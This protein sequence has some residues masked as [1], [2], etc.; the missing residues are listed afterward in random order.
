RHTIRCFDDKEVGIVQTPQFFRVSSDNWVERGAAAQQEMFYRIGMR[1]RDRRQA[2]ICVGTNAVYRREAL[3]SR[4]GMALLEHSEDIFTGMKVMDAGYRVEYLPLVLAA[5]S[6]PSTTASLASQQYRWARGNFALTT[7]PLFKRMRMTPMQR[8]SIWEGWIFYVTSALSPVVAI[9]VPVLT[10]AEAP[11]AISLAPTAMLLPALFTEFVVQPRWLHLPDGRASRRVGVISQVAHLHALRDHLTDRDQEWIPTGGVR[12]GTRRQP[13]DRIPDIVAGSAV[14]GFVTILVMVGVR[15]AQRYSLLDLAPVVV[16]AAAALPTALATRRSPEPTSHTSD[17]SHGDVLCPAVEPGAG[18]AISNPSSVGERD[19]FLDTVRAVSIIRVLFWHAL[20]YWWISWLFAA[21]PAVFY[22][23]GA[24]FAQSIARAPITRVVAARL[25]RLIVPYLSFL[26]VGLAAV[27]LAVPHELLRHWRD[28]LSWVVPYRSPAPLPWEAGWLSTPLWFIRALFLVMAMAPV[29]VAIGRRVPRWIWVP[30]FTGA[31]VGLDA[32]VAAQRTASATAIVRGIGDVVCFGGFF[33][34]GAVA[35]GERHRLGRAGRL[36]LLAVLVAVTA[37]VTIT[38]P[39]P[40]MVVNNTYVSMTLVGLCWLM[41]LLTVEDHVRSFAA[42]PVIARLVSWVTG[43]SMTIYL[44]HTLAVCVAYQLVGLPTS[45]A[46]QLVLGAVFT[47]VLVSLVSVVQPLE[48]MGRRHSTRSEQHRLRPLR[49]ALVCSIVVL[50]ATG[51]TLFPE[52]TSA[53]G[54]PAPSGRPAVGGGMNRATPA[55]A[56]VGDANSWLHAHG[57]TGAVMATMKP[58]APTPVLTVAGNSHAIGAGDRF[59]VLSVTKTMVATVAIELARDGVL[60]LDAPLP[61]IDGVDQRLTSSV[62][63]RRLLA[64]A[65]G[66]VDYRESRGYRRDAV[67]TPAQAIAVAL[68]DSDTS[69]TT[70]RYSSANYLLAGLVIEKVTGESL[71]DV[72]RTWLFEPLGL[73]DTEL[74]DNSRDGF[75]GFASGGVV[76]TVSDLSRWYDAL[77]RRRIVLDDDGLDEMVWGASQWSQF[78]GLGAWRRCPCG[79]TTAG[80]SSDYL[81]VFHDGGDVRIAYIPSLDTVFA[82]RL[83]APIYGPD[84]VADDLDDLVFEMLDD[85]IAGV[86]GSLAT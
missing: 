42:I 22:V 7:A 38:D 69:H 2:A 47:V 12:T 31:I 16:L 41:A 46:D 28:A 66:L 19:R 73:H 70:V 35:H 78:S 20:G 75:V 48:H 65:S 26:T 40:Q 53:A 86:Q 85:S 29:M 9:V 5:G 54:P 33:A 63:M 13:T 67:L 83:D 6:A 68:A 71:A 80:T 4:G 14:I 17:G 15:A 21:M 11:D 74:I 24:I 18:S 25:E 77:M 72:L 79:A 3:D 49:L 55:D 60:D 44:W 36:R 37:A 56:S 45:V 81:Y 61:P 50:L 27:A 30:V 34:L 39:P 59:E 43:S 32:L 64:H 84:R 23:S 76:S 57:A 8:L 52:N 1:A 51:P 10:L 58:G 82:I 62:T